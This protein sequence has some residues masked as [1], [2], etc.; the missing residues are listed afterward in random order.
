MNPTV[1][2][3]IIERA[4]E[5]DPASAAAEYGAQF[6]ADLEQYISRETVDRCTREEPTDLPPVRG[7]QYAGAVDPSGGSGQDS[8]TLAISHRDGERVVI[9]TVR[10]IKPPFSPAEAVTE[11]TA[12]LKEYGC[13]RVT[14]DRWGGEFCREPFRTAGIEYELA[15]RPRSDLYRDTLPLLNAG[16]LELP[17]VE[18]LAKQF[19]GLQRRKGRSGKDVIDHPQHANA[20]D[21]LANV[22][23]LAAVLMSTR[24]R[25]GIYGLVTW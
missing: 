2:E 8:M 11:F 3:R 12:V 9:D 20:H 16:Q 25:P 23:A 21:D 6:R 10:E 7:V 14:G 15:D 17:P 19:Q 1:P 18:K 5:R 22:T 4:Y 24:A 13:R